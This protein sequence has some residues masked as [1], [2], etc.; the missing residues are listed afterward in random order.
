MEKFSIAEARDKF[1]RLVRRVEEKAPVELTR[2]GKTVAVL[3]SIEEYRRLQAQQR[4][5]WDAYQT[6]RAEVDLKEAGVTEED[7]TGLR[8]PSPGREVNL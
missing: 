7:F 1:T 8:E 5:F 6:F 2:R 4:G 3:M